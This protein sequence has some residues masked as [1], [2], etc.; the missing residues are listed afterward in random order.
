MGDRFLLSRLAPVDE[1][2]FGQALKHMGAA[3]PQMRKELAEAVARLFAGR[4]PEPRPISNEEIE[5]IDHVIMLVVRLRGAV[6]RDR[7]SREI[8][9]LR[10][11]RDGAHRPHPRTPARRAGH[12]RRRPRHRARR[13]R[14]RRPGLGAADP[15]PRLRIPA[16]AQRRLRRNTRRRQRHQLADNHSPPRA[17]RPHRLS[18]RH[19]HRSRSGQA[20]SSP[21]AVRKNQNLDPERA[22]LRASQVAAA[23]ARQRV[24]AIKAAV[25]RAE[26]LAWAGR[27]KV[28]KAR[29]A[30]TAAA[31]E[32][33]EALADS[34]VQGA[35]TTPLQTTR[36]AREEE[37]EAGDALEAARS[38]V[39]RLESDL[40]EAEHAAERASKGVRAI[41]SAVLVPVA[42]RMAEEAGALRGQYLTR[43]FAISAL[44]ERL[45]GFTHLDFSIRDEEYKQ[46]CVSVREPWIAAIER[47]MSDS[48]AD[49]PMIED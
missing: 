45:D 2:Q 23:S 5:R 29:A 38:A 14:G 9:R 41:I 8:G 10:C 40:E 7:Q 18:T 13:G 48:S 15:P 37:I 35:G 44:A 3:T 1:G 19:A 36:R 16:L 43:M 22:A 4:R 47:L 12:A 11:R 39:T 24:S 26:G 20:R 25:E 31:A 6:E 34:L 32:D 42:K 49:L 33:A 46:L 21:I 17:R 30:V 27:R 28:E